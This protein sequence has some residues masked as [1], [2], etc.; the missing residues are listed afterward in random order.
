MTQKSH[1]IAGIIGGLLFFAAVMSAHLP[2]GDSKPSDIIDYFGTT[3]HQASTMVIAYVLAL[4]SFLL[5]WFFVGVARRLR[6]GEG[7]RASDVSLLAAITGVATVAALLLA[8]GALIAMSGPLLFGNQ[9]APGD[10]TVTVGWVAIGLIVVAMLPAAVAMFA[11]S[12]AAGRSGALPRWNVRVGYVCAI[13]LAPG[14]LVFS[15]MLALTVWLV[16]TGITLIRPAPARA[17]AAVQ[18]AAA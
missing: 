3:G 12:L 2:G 10:S 9:A 1:G 6:A 16:S 8:A 5:A 17:A 14:S 15:P 13:V 11:I 4:A 18:P 7:G